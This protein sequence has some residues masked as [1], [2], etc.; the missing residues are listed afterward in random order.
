MN[1]LKQIIE[2]IG[3]VLKVSELLGV[4]HSAIHRWLIANALPRTEWTGETDYAQRLSDALGGKLSKTQILEIAH[5]R[6]NPKAN[7][8]GRGK[9]IKSQR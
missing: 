2:S 5:P 7:P 9:T 6:N 8:L 1:D 3:S 4:S